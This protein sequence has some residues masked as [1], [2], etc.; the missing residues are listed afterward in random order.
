MQKIYIDCL[1]D[2]DIPKNSNDLLIDINLSE[3]KNAQAFS[4]ASDVIKYA[5]LPHATIDYKLKNLIHPI[6]FIAC[7]DD[8][9]ILKLCKCIN[10]GAT[11]LF[12][13]SVDN[14]LNT[15]CCLKLLSV[16]PIYLNHESPRYDQFDE[17]TLCELSLRESHL[18]IPCLIGYKSH[19]G[20]D[21][22]QWNL[23]WSPRIEDLKRPCEEIKDFDK[24]SECSI[25]GVQCSEYSSECGWPA[26]DSYEYKRIF[27]GV[28]LLKVA[29]TTQ[30]VF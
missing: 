7:R 23:R 4:Q 13:M 26:K 24:P 28:G 8:E 10:Q 15:L 22:L 20:H 30:L 16:L 18:D 17:C 21:E 29:D 12:G 14:P 19:E 5:E 27:K 6:N 9:N 1:E 11:V 2:F 25:G 3:Q